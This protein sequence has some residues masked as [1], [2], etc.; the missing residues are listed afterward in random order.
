MQ[1]FQTKLLKLRIAKNYS[2][3]LD[4]VEQKLTGQD[5]TRV[6]IN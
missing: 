5:S 6:K 3:E 4:M 1:V 2:F